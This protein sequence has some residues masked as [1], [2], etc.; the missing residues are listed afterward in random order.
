MWVVQHRHGTRSPH[1][2]R[3]DYRPLLTGVFRV[4]TTIPARTSGVLPP[5]DRRSGRSFGPYR[6]EDC[7]Y[8]HPLLWH[9]DVQHARLWLYRTYRRFFVTKVP[10]LLPTR[11]ACPSGDSR[12]FVLVRSRARASQNITSMSVCCR[13]HCY[14]VSVSVH[15]LCFR[16]FWNRVIPLSKLHYG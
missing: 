11:P 4:S 12:R 9:R 8:T 2:R 5:A 14:R 6:L 7:S 10:L 13:R 15:P 3:R 16:D 1:I